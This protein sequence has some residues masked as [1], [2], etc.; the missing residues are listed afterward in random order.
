MKVPLE[1]SY[2]NV[3]KTNEVEETIRNEV[4]RLEKVCDYLSSCRVAIE[5]RQK[6]QNQGSPFHVR[7]LLTVPPGHEISSTKTENKGDMH[8]SLT[9][10]IRKAFKGA[11]KHLKRIVEQQRDH[12]KKHEQ[13]EVNAVIVKIFQ[14]EGYGFLKNNEGDE[15]YFHKNSVINDEFKRLQQGIVVRYVE[16]MGKKGPQASTVRILARSRYT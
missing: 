3:E 16:E 4:Q 5:E 6:Y 14:D 12:V 8:E 9:T 15:I 13:Q 1:I 2:R 10:V 11:E 7:V